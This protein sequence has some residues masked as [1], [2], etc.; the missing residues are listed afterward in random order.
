MLA[1]E[2]L[3]IFRIFRLGEDAHDRLRA[4]APHEDAHRARRARALTSVDLV[5]DR[6][7]SV[8]AE[9]RGCC[10]S[11]AGYVRHHGRRLAR[12]GVRGSRHRG[13]A[14]ASPSPVTWSPTPDHVARLLAAEQPAFALERLEDVAVSHRRGRRPS[15]RCSAMSRWKPR[16]VMTV[17]ATSV[18]AEAGARARRVIWSPSTRL[19]ALVDRRACGRRSPSNAT[20]RSR[21]SARDELLQE[22]VRSVAP[23]PT[24]MFEPSGSTPIAVDLRAE[25]RRARAARCSENAPFARVD[26]DPKAG[27]SEP[28]RST[29][30][31]R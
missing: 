29:T 15:P 26:P 17:T 27:E 25:L 19:A 23:Q 7:R 16:F 22:R 9:S 4:R 28:K 5:E 10:A 13:A 14:A 24:L 21:P 3:C 30:C 8:G 12:G 18:D 11:P 1:H 20:P 6:L 31:A 2:L